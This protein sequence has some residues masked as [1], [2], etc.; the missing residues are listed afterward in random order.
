VTIKSEV[1]EHAS[2]FIVT[3]AYIIRRP[4]DPENA[5]P[6]LEGGLLA[7][8]V[9]RIKLGYYPLPPAEGARLR[10]LLAFEPGASAVDPC[11]GTGAALHQLTEG[12]E[13]E[14]HAVELDAARAAAASASGIATVH[15]NL[16]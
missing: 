6:G 7:R 4:I 5:Y 12:A 3:L 15:G 2:K 10:R 9:S 16:F 8:N 11:A 1:Y 13:V 14:R